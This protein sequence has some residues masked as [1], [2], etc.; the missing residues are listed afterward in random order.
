MDHRAKGRR[1]KSSSWLLRDPV[2]PEPHHSSLPRHGYSVS[3][4]AAYLPERLAGVRGWTDTLEPEGQNYVHVNRFASI[5]ELSHH[6]DQLKAQPTS[7]TSSHYEVLEDNFPAPSDHGYERVRSRCYTTGS[8]SIYC[9]ASSDQVLPSVRP[10]QPTA[11]SHY[12]VTH[13]QV[14]THPSYGTQHLYERTPG[15]LSRASDTASHGYYN[16]DTR[17]Q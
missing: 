3:K 10:R 6:Y 16:L 8:D 15:F 2:R 13:S 1:S 7:P 14:A 17:T 5:G 11:E 12:T 9:Y 4:S